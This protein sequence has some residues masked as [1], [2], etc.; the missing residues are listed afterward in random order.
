[1]AVLVPYGEKRTQQ[2]RGWK[3]RCYV[4]TGTHVWYAATKPS[5]NAGDAVEWKPFN[6]FVL[7]LIIANC[8]FLVFDDPI[9]KCEVTA[10]IYGRSAAVSA[11]SSAIC[12]SNAAIYARNDAL[13]VCGAIN[14]DDAAMHG[15]NSHIS[16]GAG[17]GLKRKDRMHPE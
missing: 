10:S 11:G 7:F 3:S 4:M 14:V 17:G 1:M 16:S 8:I 9:C 15:C 2:R 6:H 5:T 13:C 12:G